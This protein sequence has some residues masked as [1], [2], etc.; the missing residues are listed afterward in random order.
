[1]K[2]FLLGF[3]CSGVPDANEW[4]RLEVDESR[5]ISLAREVGG[6]A[7]AEFHIQLIIDLRN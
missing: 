1:M 2:T 7:L 3:G 5:G 6:D 4:T